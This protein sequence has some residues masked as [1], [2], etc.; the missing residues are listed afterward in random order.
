[1]KWL[2]SGIFEYAIATGVVMG[3]PV[4]AAKWLTRPKETAPTIEY[5]LEQVLA[6]LRVLEPLLRLDAPD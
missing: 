6:M 3:N 1:M 2:L 5:T 4:P